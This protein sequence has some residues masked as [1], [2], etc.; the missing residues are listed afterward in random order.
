MKTLTL[1]SLFIVAQ[2]AFA[3]NFYS[4]NGIIRVIVKKDEVRVLLPNTDK[5]DVAGVLASFFGKG[6]EAAEKKFRD[7]LSK[8]KH[9][10]M[11]LTSAT[12][13]KDFE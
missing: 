4:Q 3:E 9:V 1:L 12:E 6:D 13:T 11:V 2:A 7:L 5:A 10:T 8:S